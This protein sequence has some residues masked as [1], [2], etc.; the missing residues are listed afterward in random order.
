MTM[1]KDIKY[2]LIGIAVTIV[3]AIFISSAYS[4]V[5]DMHEAASSTRETASSIVETALIISEEV[6]ELFESV[7]ELTPEDLFELSTKLQTNSL[8]TGAVGLQAATFAMEVSFLLWQL[9]IFFGMLALGLA[10]ISWGYTSYVHRSSERSF[11][12]LLRKIDTTSK[13]ARKR[14]Q[15]IDKRLEKVEEVLQV[16]RAAKQ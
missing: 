8:A 7:P 5:S 13:P 14:L 6:F 12:K 10:I 3:A 16:L 15:S 1:L 11:K 9:G 4:D 2:I